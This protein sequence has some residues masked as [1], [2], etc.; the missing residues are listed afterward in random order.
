MNENKLEISYNKIRLNY[1]YNNSLSN[2][3]C[4]FYDYK[5]IIDNYGNMFVYYRKY[6]QNSLV[7]DKYYDKINYDNR[8]N[9]EWNDKLIIKDNIPITKIEFEKIK[10]ILSMN[11]LI[12]INIDIMINLIKQIKTNIK[13]NDLIHLLVKEKICKE[14]YNNWSFCK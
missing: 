5:I 9:A 1:N 8:N 10:E 6:I 12:K 7:D 4:D 11:P 2:E 3:Q 14:N 13:Y